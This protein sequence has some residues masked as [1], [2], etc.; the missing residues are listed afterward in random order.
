MNI[1]QTSY[2]QKSLMPGEEA[3][4]EARLHWVTY[5]KAYAAIGMALL[6]L[7]LSALEPIA[8]IGVPIVA[9][10]ALV[11]WLRSSCTQLLVTNK[12]VIAKDGII[13]IHTEEIRNVK[14]ESI[15]IHQ[16]IMGRIL[17][18]ATIHF[19]GTGNSDVYFEHVEDPWTV[20][21]AAEIIVGGE[22]TTPM[23]S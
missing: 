2:L 15:E 4:V 3:L 1:R 16:T 21:N 12:R 11:Y 19:S 14:V 9:T 20:K 5:L 18:Y 7:V 13:S 10:M 6:L 22:H 23:E 8:L 17:G